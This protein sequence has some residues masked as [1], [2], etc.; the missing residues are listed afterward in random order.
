MTSSGGPKSKS[1]ADCQETQKLETPKKEALFA[2][3]GGVEVSA[4]L[5]GDTR[6]ATR[7]ARRWS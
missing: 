2:S 4:F 1:I 6:Q 7:G 3:D 5:G